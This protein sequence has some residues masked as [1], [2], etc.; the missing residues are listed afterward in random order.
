MLIYIIYIFAPQWSKINV[1]CVSMTACQV[2]PHA[3]NGVGFFMSLL[4]DKYL[5][6]FTWN[7]TPMLWYTKY[8]ATHSSNQSKSR[9]RYVVLFMPVDEETLLALLR[10]S[11]I[12]AKL[13]NTY[14]GWWLCI[15]VFHMKATR[16]NFVSNKGPKSY[17][18][19]PSCLSWLLIENLLYRMQLK[20]S[21][22]L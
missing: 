18:V 20:A 8:S 17:L 3:V 19:W 4:A 21:C 15:L 16:A 22:K 6:G 1:R 14:H 5:F 2:C 12:Y 10:I 9:S 11:N 13:K 7:Y